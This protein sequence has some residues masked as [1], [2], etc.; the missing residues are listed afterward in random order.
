[1]ISPRLLDFSPFFFLISS[2]LGTADF[3]VLLELS[4]DGYSLLCSKKRPPRHTPSLLFNKSIQKPQVWER[5]RLCPETSPKFYVNEFGFWST[6][7][8]MGR[9][10]SD[11]NS[12]C[13]TVR[14][15]WCWERGIG[16]RF[17]KIIIVVRYVCL[18]MTHE[19]MNMNMEL[20]M[21]ECMIADHDRNHHSFQIS[22]RKNSHAQLHS[23]L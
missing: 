7:V 19:H 15:V 22:D 20:H 23:G 9:G 17:L 2:P 16:T 12:F 1:M 10:I 14:L 4:G 3:F 18:N 6:V 5:S 21:Y 13:L 8:W 11:G